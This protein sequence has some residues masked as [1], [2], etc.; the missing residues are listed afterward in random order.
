MLTATVASVAVAAP[1][2]SVTHGVIRLATVDDAGRSVTF[3]LYWAAPAGHP[4]AIVVVFHGHGHNA[5]E[6]A[7]E[8]A[9]TARR[10]RAVVVAPFTRETKASKGPF[11]SVDEEARGAASA[12]AWARHRF[13]VQPTY[14]LCVSM[15]CTGLAYFA[16][17]ATRPTAGDADAR[18]V[19]SR[20]P[21]PIRGIVVSEG[22]SNL[23]ETWA[24]AAAADHTSQAEIEAETRTASGPATPAQNAAA[25]RSRSLALL[26][27]SSLAG[28]GVRMAAVVHDVDDGL[29]PVNQVA[30]TRVALTAAGIPIHGVTVARN[31]PTCSTDGQTTATHYASDDLDPT[32]CLAGHASEIRPELPVMRATFDALQLLIAG[33]MRAGEYTEDPDAG[34][35]Y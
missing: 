30:E 25:Y 33:T 35:F 26:P 13:H 9:M 5:D 14:L 22:L 8:L 16:D 12:I 32:V 28:L 3:P 19:Q 4:R 7:H 23:V 10:D 34:A 6:W 17:A 2:P 18:W 1:R 27:T 24:E 21:L 11:D 29:V 20:H 31:T 15:G